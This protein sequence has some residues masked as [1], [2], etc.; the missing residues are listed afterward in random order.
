VDESVETG[1]SDVKRK[2][3][4]FSDSGD[5]DEGKRRGF[6]RKNAGWISL[7]VFLGVLWV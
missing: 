4:D 7:E 2:F 1:Y 3:V 6:L 5:D